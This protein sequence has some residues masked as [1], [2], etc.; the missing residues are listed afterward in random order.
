MPLEPKSEK[1]PAETYVD[2]LLNHFGN[3][4]LFVL[5][6]YRGKTYAGILQEIASCPGLVHIQRVQQPLPRTFV[7]TLIHIMGETQR[8]TAIDSL[9]LEMRIQFYADL[10]DHTLAPITPYQ[11]AYLIE[12][13]KRKV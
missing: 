3:K 2:Q 6:D 13:E 11:H 12:D 1:S 5:L 8:Y 10:S 4:G 9:P 7:D